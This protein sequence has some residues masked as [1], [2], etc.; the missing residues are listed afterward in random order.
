MSERLPNDRVDGAGAPVRPRGSRVRRIMGAVLALLCVAG[1][2]LFSWRRVHRPLPVVPVLPPAPAS[3]VRPEAV[4]V[5]LKPSSRSIEVECRKGG[6]W[7]ALG[8]GEARFVEM[9]AGPWRISAEGGGLRVGGALLPEARA[10]LRPAE[11]RFRLGKA[12]YRGR[13]RVEAR[14]DGAISATNLVDVEDYVRSVVGG[15]MYSRWPLETLMAQ[16]VTART[17]TLHTLAVRGHMV[18]RDMAYRGVEAECRAA[19]LATELTQGIVLTW[20]GR[21]LP[22]YFHSTCGG[23]TVPADAVFAEERIPPLAGVDCPWCRASPW[24][25]WRA[26]MP[27]AEVAQRLHRKGIDEVHSIEPQGAEQDGYARYVLVNGTVRLSADAFRWALGPSRI[28][29]ARFSVTERN[30]V[31]AFQGRGYGHGV[32]LCQWGARGM[33]REGYTWQEILLHYYPEVAIQKAY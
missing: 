18:L 7:Y 8:D 22:A 6:T 15:E 21:L 29:S 14:P 33:A 11:G 5:L 28:K 9:G 12:T 10:E 16:A 32:G 4:R 1:V 13:L 2:L 30:G 27:A 24:Y 17:F 20:G 26:E 3:I 19:D 23:S 31:F 25:E